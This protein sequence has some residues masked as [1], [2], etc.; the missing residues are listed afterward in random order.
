MN[1]AKRTFDVC[2]AIGGLLF[3][4]PIMLAVAAAIVLDDGRPIFFRQSRLGR[5][6]KSFEILKFRS[7]RDGQVTRAGRVLRA[8]GLDELPQ[9]FNILRGEL[10]AV[11]PRPV[12]AGDAERYGWSGVNAEP[13]WR[14]NPGLTGLAQLAARTPREALAM[15]LAYA[16]RPRFA[17]DC[18]VIAMSF[19]VNVLGKSRARRL[20]FGGRHQPSLRG[21]SS[22]ASPAGLLHCRRE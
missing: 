19:V 11:G 4:G 20:F 8:T 9:F 16:Q 21:T 3:F 17:L 14:I 10:S 13:R 12:T 5:G 7:M 18:R 22:V 1:R 2:G 15:D 6:R